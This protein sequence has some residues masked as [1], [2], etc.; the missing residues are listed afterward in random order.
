MGH[1]DRGPR[2]GVCSPRGGPGFPRGRLFLQHRCSLTVV[3]YHVLFAFPRRLCV[4]ASTRLV[5]WGVGQLADRPAVNR[6][7]GGSSPP[8]PVSSLRVS[9]TTPSTDSCSHA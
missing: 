7:V 4:S 1:V 3:T 9:P 8:A 6:E 2:S 5:F